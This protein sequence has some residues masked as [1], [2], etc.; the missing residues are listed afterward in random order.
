MESTN[1]TDDDP[2]RAMLASGP[3]LAA[4]DLDAMEARVGVKLPAD[5][6]AFL[7][8]T[9]GAKTEGDAPAFVDL[10]R[11]QEVVALTL[12]IR[13]ERPDMDLAGIVF[14]GGDGSRE[15]LCLDLR[16]SPVVRLLDITFDS[17]DDTPWT[18]PTFT[19]AVRRVLARGWFD[20]P[21]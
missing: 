19:A 15:M 2:M 20:E 8:G 16:E 6:R 5:Y 18:E 13:E 21:S 1:M 9:D 17:L 10:W 12:Q 14:V 3:G 4:A 7:G 11:G